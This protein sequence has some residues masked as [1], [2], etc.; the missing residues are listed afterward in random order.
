MQ[1]H[2]V[3]C[4]PCT[5]TLFKASS[6][7]APAE[8]CLFFNLSYVCPEPVLANHVRFFGMNVS[9]QKDKRHF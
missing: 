8:A 4:Q 6:N 1:W 7:D 9:S 2:S 3:A 5:A